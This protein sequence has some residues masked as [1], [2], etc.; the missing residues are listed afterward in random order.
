MS[1][2]AATAIAVEAGNITPTG[3][4]VEETTP[5]DFIL[6]RA[7]PAAAKR[8]GKKKKAAGTTKPKRQRRPKKVAK[9]KSEPRAE[10]SAATADPQLEEALRRWRLTEAKRRGVPAFRVFN[11]RTLTAIASKRPKTA[12][13]LLAIPGMGIT[14]VEKYGHQIYRI[15]DEYS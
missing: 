15:L 1:Y 10:D 4:S 13:E 14:G 2:L 7:A 11:D 3:Q 5:I 12:R 6:K 9:V 8:K